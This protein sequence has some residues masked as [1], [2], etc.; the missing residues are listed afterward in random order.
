MK[1]Y[2]KF[3]LTGNKLFPVWLAFLVLFLIPYIFVQYN[4]QTLKTEDPTQALSNLGNMLQWYGFMFVLLL[5]EYAIIFYIAKMFIEGMEYKEEKFL[6]S[7]TFGQY[8]GILIPGFLLS[9]VTLGIYTPWLAAKILRFYS[10]NTTYKTDSFEFK[11]KGGDL[12]VIVLLSVILPLIVVSVVVGIFSAG[13]AI[14]GTLNPSIIS[15]V[16]MVAM[17][18]ILIRPP[19]KLR[20][21]HL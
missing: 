17:L 2:F 9:I 10:S 14:E 18:I 19:L 20:Q 13:A 3:N 7:G 16:M 11:G 21:S 6:F 12:F 8:L 1:N 4:L 15:T 5:I